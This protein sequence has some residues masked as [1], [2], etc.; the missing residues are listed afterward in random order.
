M[1][2]EA[3]ASFVTDFPIRSQIYGPSVALRAGAMEVLLSTATRLG[4]GWLYFAN[5]LSMALVIM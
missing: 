1:S 2:A 5:W 3:G 4:Q